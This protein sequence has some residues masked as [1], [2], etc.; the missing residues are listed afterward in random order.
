MNKKQSK[1]F[2]GLRDD[3]LK[4]IFGDVMPANVDKEL[5]YVIQGEEVSLEHFIHD[6]NTLLVKNG[7][8]FAATEDYKKTSR[9]LD[10]ANRR[11]RELY[12]ETLAMTNTLARVVKKRKEAERDLYRLQHNVYKFIAAKLAELEGIDYT[13]LDG[14]DK[15]YWRE[16]A[17]LEMKWFMG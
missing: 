5:R 1:D 12:N 7:K 13:S 16:F 17:A 9:Q 11:N 6:I 10:E 3:N 4:T 14:V 8:L 15:H 2:L